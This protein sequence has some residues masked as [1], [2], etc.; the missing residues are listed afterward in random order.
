LGATLLSEPYRTLKRRIRIMTTPIPKRPW[1]RGGVLAGAGVLLFAVAC[2]APGPVDAPEDGVQAA[3]GNEA[4]IYGTVRHAPS[5]DPLPFVQVFVPGTGRGTLSDRE[6][7]FLI[8]HV[9]AGTRAVVAEL[10]GY[11]Q[12]R[13]EVHVPPGDRIEV[14]FGLE[15]TA[16]RMDPLVVRVG[17]GTG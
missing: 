5:G 2:W 11:G 4:E 7:R 14:S 17:P 10:I 8:R 6:G 16:V 1:I 9:P 3:A 15:V 13:Q 12:G